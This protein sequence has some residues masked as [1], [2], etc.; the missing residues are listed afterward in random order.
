[1]HHCP[2]RN[3]AKVQ[4]CWAQHNLFACREVH[5]QKHA[6]GKVDIGIKPVHLLLSSTLA[7]AALQP[8]SVQVEACSARLYEHS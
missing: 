5:E 6:G 4:V 2:N 8:A 3:A 7:A 1:M